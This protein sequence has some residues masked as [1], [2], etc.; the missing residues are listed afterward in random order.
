[1]RVLA[2]SVAICLATAVSAEAPSIADLEA[3]REGSMKKL[4]FHTE[5]EPIE[6]GAFVDL[7][8]GAHAL[9][10]YR[11]KVVVL[12]FWATWCAPCREEMPY[13]DALQGEMGGEDFQV[14][15]VATGRNSPTGL[16][17]F[18][19]ETEIENLTLFEDPKQALAREMA[20]LGLPVTVILD[21]EGNEIARLRGEAD[22]NSDSAKAIIAAMLPD[23]AE[24][25]DEGDG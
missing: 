17:R 13:L 20:V 8:G 15:A 21:R 22:W 9:S 19:E 18:W 6:I 25:G 3:L 5:P 12:N 2:S 11:D 10:D 23:T 1:M 16:R 4:V 24:A 7:E 14:L